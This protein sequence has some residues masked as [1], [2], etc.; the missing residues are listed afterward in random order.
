MRFPKPGI[1][2]YYNLPLSLDLSPWTA[3]IVGLGLN[4]A[5]YEAEIYRA[6]KLMID[7]HG[8]DA[9]TMA[10]RMADA[11]RE[12]GDRQSELVWHRIRPAVEA[13][14]TQPSEAAD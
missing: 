3:A 5:A 7:R 13:L 2:V 12:R 9:P 14:S 1:A 8:A 6:A 4:Y 10:A 11:F